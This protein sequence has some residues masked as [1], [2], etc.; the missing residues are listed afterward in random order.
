MKLAPISLAT[1]VVCFSAAA[2]AQAPCT[3]EALAQKPGALRASRL[4]GSTGG[5]SAADMARARATLTKI[6]Q[7]LAAGYRPVGVVGDYS[8][9]FSGG[10]TGSTFGYSLYLLKYNCDEATPDR[11]DHYIGTDTPTVVRIDANVINAF[12]LSGAD[13]SD[14]TF[15]G[16]LYMRN[17]PKKVGGVYYLG[18]DPAGSFK[19]KQKEYTWLVTYGDEYPF[20]VLTR[21]E[22]LLL[23]K[24]RL[25]KSIRENGNSSGYYNEFVN[26]VDEYLRK[27]ESELIFPAIVSRT[28]DERFTGFLQEGD[29]SAFYAIKHNPAYYRK[30]LPK[31]AAQFF[32]VTYSVYE[33]DPVYPANIDAVKKALDLN[34]LRAMLGK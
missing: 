13:T 10:P 20:T 5:M 33:G 18:D 30:G 15:R 22:Y 24:E 27:S 34:A 14:N 9:K 31:S 28:D 17:I 19:E 4:S 26:R 21:R 7:T 1:I 16:F 23:T 32:T 29:R 3:S 25:Q 6:H 12:S 11:S 2:L 8:F